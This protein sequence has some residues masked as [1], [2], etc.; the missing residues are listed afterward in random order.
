ME[1]VNSSSC[2]GK[3]VIKT[4]S[5]LTYGTYRSM[6]YIQITPD[7]RCV[8]NQHLRYTEFPQYVITEEGLSCPFCRR[9]RLNKLSTSW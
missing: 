5:E 1:I 3:F 2:F 7:Y 4:T 8:N 9:F 6:I